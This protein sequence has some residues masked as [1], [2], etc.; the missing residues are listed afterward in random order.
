MSYINIDNDSD[1]LSYLKKIEDKKVQTIA[2]DIEAESNLHAY[3]ERLCLA[4]IFDGVDNIIID[5]FNI[6]TDSLKRLFENS[7]ILKVMYDAGSDLSLL[8][9]TIGIEIKSILDLRPAS[10]LLDYEKKAFIPWLHLSLELFW[11]VNENFR[12]ITGLK[13]QFQNR[14]LN[15]L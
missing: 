6:T 7:N 13:D 3:G 10:E 15:T 2:L 9:N 8:K 12:N 4:Q 14:H 5:P 11:K 1:L